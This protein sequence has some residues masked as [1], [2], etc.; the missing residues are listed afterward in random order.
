[1]TRAVLALGSNIGDRVAHLRAARTTL[2]GRLVAASS[3]YETVPVGPIAQDMFLNAVVIVDDPTHAPANWLALAMRLETAALRVRTV[4]G[5]P[6][7]L[8][9]DV[10]AVSMVGRELT[11]DTST[12]QVPH[13][14]ASH[15]AF[16]LLPWLEADPNAMLGDTPVANLVAALPDEARAGVTRYP[17]EGWTPQELPR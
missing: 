3:I 12:L 10:V 15:R 14:E 16:V 5:G 2:K 9:I 8:D 13:P 6:R 7:T 11:S 17:A 4:V 1:M